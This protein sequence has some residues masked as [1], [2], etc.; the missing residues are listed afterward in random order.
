[1]MT[2]EASVS[3]EPSAAQGVVTPDRGRVE[4]RSF[5]QLSFTHLR[6]TASE[7]AGSSRAGLFLRNVYQKIRCPN[8]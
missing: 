1:M 7:Q 2:D 5:L 4:H 8:R 6:E 3:P